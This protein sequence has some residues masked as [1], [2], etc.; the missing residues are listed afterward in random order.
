MS[1]IDDFLKYNPEFKEGCLAKKN[2]ENDFLKWKNKIPK[3]ERK[4]YWNDFLKYEIKERNK[5]WDSFKR[6]NFFKIRYQGFEYITHPSLVKE[7]YHEYKFIDLLTNTQVIIKHKGEKNWPILTINEH[8]Y[9][10]ELL[11]C[12][13][14][15]N[16]FKRREFEDYLKFKYITKPMGCMGCFTGLII[17]ILII[18]I[19]IK[20]A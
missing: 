16:P 5:Y 19:A 11:E 17:G 10:N 9:S 6:S 13:K 3:I 15:N 20:F 14:Q 7:S 1:D 12:F 4:K 2:F 8:E 18:M